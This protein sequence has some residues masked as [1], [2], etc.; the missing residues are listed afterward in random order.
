M[1]NSLTNASIIVPTY[2][3]AENLRPLV[4]RAFAALR[5]ADITA[6]MII[7]D[8]NSRDGTE[9]VVAALSAE[10]P[11]RLIVRRKERGLSSAVLAG[12]QEA[13][14]GRLVVMDADLQH[15]PEVIPVLIRRF[16]E[17]DF[18]FVIGTRY[19][20]GGGIA[21]DWPFH[22]RI[23]SRTATLLARP[24]VPLSDPMSGFFALR[25]ERWEGAAP[26][27]PIGYKIA[28]EL[29]V[30]GRCT[31]PAEVPICFA[32]RT[33]GIS[34]LSAAEQMRYLRHL[35]RLYRFKYPRLFRLVVGCVLV[36]LIAAIV[37][38][39]RVL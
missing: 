39:F 38:G 15:P 17:G 10:Y 29:Y 24:L 7:V 33:A 18:D 27:D 4:E 28:L 26:L 11:V 20:G 14:Y 1:A 30:K 12:F 6:E 23:V 21:E 5:A 13:Q 22:R 36:G 9:D 31:R 32:A 37:M 3:E 19:G 34:K 35:G 25:R 8:D 2:R 16:D